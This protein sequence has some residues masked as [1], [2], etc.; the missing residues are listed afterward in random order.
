M[1]RIHFSAADLERLRIS[2]S[3]AF[4]TI[5]ASLSTSRYEP[6]A[7]RAAHGQL[8]RRAGPAGRALRE[9]LH[10]DG[11]H[12]PDFLTPAPLADDL[13]LG[14]ELDLAAATPEWRLSRDCRHL[15]RFVGQSRVAEGLARADTSVTRSA[16]LGLRAFH[17]AAYGDSW[18]DV[19]R[20]LAADAQRRRRDLEVH[21]LDHVLANLHP[22]VRWR[23][24]TLTVVKNSYYGDYD[25][26][27][28]G[29]VLVP[30][31]GRL[32]TV[33]TMI[34]PWEPVTIGYPVLRNPPRHQPATPG[35]PA[36]AL[37]RLLGH[38]RARLLLAI[39]A[40]PELT[41][42]ELAAWLGISV[43]S[44]SEHASVLR[45]CG[46]ATTR[47]ERNGRAACGQPA[48]RGGAACVPRRARAAAGGV[49]SGRGA[50]RRAR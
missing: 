43:A 26:T 50:S 40:A 11:S 33:T 1:L 25:R 45:S 17:R 14:D 41:T 7:V 22:S 28:Q 49:L 42:T 19:H 47:R 8:V 5:T 27:G 37:A 3:P 24:P 30:C 46:L 32:Q 35:R 6:A 21:G 18:S 31:I 9:L 13:Q 15:E 29:I 39:D 4:Q 12:V 48:R 10:L 36:P 34:N 38:T 23:R 20:V 2:I 44:V 16:L